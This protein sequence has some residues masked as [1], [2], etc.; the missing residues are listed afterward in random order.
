M[1]DPSLPRMKDVAALL[2]VHPTT[3]SLALRGHPSI[4]ETTQLR[5]R[6]AAEKLGYRPNP[7]VS[8]LMSH[9]RAP[10][11][12]FRHTTLAFVT[13]SFPP[14]E[15]RKSQTLRDLLGGASERARVRGYKVEEFALFADRMTPPRF[16]QVLRS[17]GI[18]GLIIAPLRNAS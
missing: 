18:L 7:L 16:N 9:R 17:R 2:G 12:A 13:S 4:P 14:D 11:L 1:K 15:W 10:H 8:A 5:V 6:R 3:V